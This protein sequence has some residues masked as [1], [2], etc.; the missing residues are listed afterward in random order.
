MDYQNILVAIADEKATITFNRPQKR[1]AIDERTMDELL[2]LLKELQDNPEIRVAVL[3]G[4]GKDFC[5]GADLDWM[6]TTQ[7][8]DE[9]LLQKQNMKL[10]KVFTLWHDLPCL[11]IA[12]VHGNVVGGALGL[13]AAS[14]IVISR[15]GA[16][17][18]FSEVTLG[19]MPATIAPFV[20]QRTIHSQLRN[21]MITAMPFNSEQASNFGLVDHVADEVKESELLK[22]LDTAIR[23]TEPNAVAQTKKL[24]N[25]ILL[26]RI[27]E[28]LD[29]YT[30][31]L[32]A[33]VR[34]SE[35]ASQRIARFFESIDHRS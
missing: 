32:L 9:S 16:M 18:R 33:R 30:T 8:M 29:E 22:E 25:D 28:P 4:N 27:T 14:N 34:R 7:N 31:L 10:Q 26:N 2:H 13:V 20:L 12:C 24:T 35:A 6:R 3:R 15:P 19:L 11:T 21:A 17:F 23:K 1:N 5:A